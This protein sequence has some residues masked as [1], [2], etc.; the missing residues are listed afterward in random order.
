MIFNYSIL[1]VII[2][3][4][5]CIYFLIRIITNKFKFDRYLKILIYF[6]LCYVFI[7]KFIFGGQPE[8]PKESTSL[9][10][11]NKVIDVL[12]KNMY[13]KSVRIQ[14]NNI[15]LSY[16][17]Y[18]FFPS[19]AKNENANKLYMIDKDQTR[20]EIDGIGENIGIISSAGIIE[21]TGDTNNITSDFE[22]FKI[23]Y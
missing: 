3:F 16:R 5:T 20:F 18:G 13:I 1:P 2:L 19:F 4:V 9:F 21:F 7:T 6:F 10:L 11:D 8:I 17:I 14:E 23:S 12:D 15:Y 22:I